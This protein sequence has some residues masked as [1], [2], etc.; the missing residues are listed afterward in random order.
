MHFPVCLWVPSKIIGGTQGRELDVGKKCVYVCVCVWRGGVGGHS[1]YAKYVQLTPLSGRNKLNGIL[2]NVLTPKFLHLEALSASFTLF[3]GQSRAI[4]FEGPS[5]KNS[6]ASSEKNQAQVCLG[7]RLPVV[8]TKKIRDYCV[9]ESESF[10]WSIM[11]RFCVLGFEIY[12]PLYEKERE[13]TRVRYCSG[14]CYL[15]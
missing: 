11:P 6:Y 2:R 13:T 12:P 1:S 14:R 3:T 10:L 7:I 5:S 4:A 8:K 9:Q 15:S